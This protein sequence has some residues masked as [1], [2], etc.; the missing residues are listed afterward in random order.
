M[1][2]RGECNMPVRLSS[3]KGAFDTP[4]FLCG[5]TMRLRHKWWRPHIEPALAQLYIERRRGE[6]KVD[7][8]LAAS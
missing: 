6:I 3:Q 5:Q 7:T 8:R 1:L 2:T 4:P